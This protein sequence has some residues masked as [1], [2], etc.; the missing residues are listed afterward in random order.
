M[1]DDQPPPASP[2]WRPPPGPPGAEPAAAPVVPTYPAGP[3]AS[4][5]SYLQNGYA[6]ATAYP[7]YPEEVRAPRGLAVAAVV[8]AVVLTAVQVAS[9]ATSWSASDDL[10]RLAGSGTDVA[11]A[12]LFAYDLVNTLYLPVGL[13]TYVVACLWL[14]RARAN[15]IRTAPAWTH[16][17]SKVWVWLGWWVPVVQLW[18]PYQ[19]VRDV[20]AGSVRDSTSGRLGLWWTCWLVFII[21]TRVAARMAPVS[22]V[23][24]AELARALPWAETVATVA[25][26]AASV[27]WVRTVWQ[28]TEAQ[29]RP[30][31]PA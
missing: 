1:T 4:A 20:R 2:A 22:G 16:A 19:V 23:P 17:R 5:P 9:W 26:L 6:A 25:L 13:A 15:A 24:D 29:A 11:A 8:L 21:A 27:I 31:P 30:A 10:V 12:P 18:F 7:A 3:A 14:Y 28:V